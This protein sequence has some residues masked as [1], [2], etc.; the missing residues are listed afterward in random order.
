M[1]IR[2]FSFYNIA[3]DMGFMRLRVQKQK[4]LSP[5]TGIALLAEYSP[6]LLRGHQF[7]QP[8]GT[9]LPAANS[10]NAEVCFGIRVRSRRNCRLEFVRHVGTCIRGMLHTV[11]AKDIW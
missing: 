2:T 9:P 8:A 10:C 7:K 3:T 11:I 4:R 6:F 1:L 5:F